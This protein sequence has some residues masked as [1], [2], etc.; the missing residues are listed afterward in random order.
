MNTEHAIR[1]YIAQVI[2]LSLATSR[3][4]RPWASEVHFAYDDALNLYFRST[5]DRRHSQ[6]I[7]DNPYVAGTIVT[8]H[9]R[10]QKVRGVY[11]EGTA[12]LLTGVDAR[13]PAYTHYCAR[14]GTGP[15][16]LD[17]ASS[18]GGHQFYQITVTDF[19]LFDGYESNPSQKF[20]LAW[21]GQRK[22][23]RTE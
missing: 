6:E 5:P 19:Y 7:M 8:Q 13:H 16:I 12:K 9:H 14:L 18:A 15:E 3:D 21:A 23:S 4:N 17:D 1:D 20:H 22:S 11:F 2:H 10:G